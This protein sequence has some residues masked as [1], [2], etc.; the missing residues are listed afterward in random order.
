[1][2]PSPVFL[3]VHCC[4]QNG[5]WPL[6][7]CGSQYIYIYIPEGSMILGCCSQDILGSQP[8]AAPAPASPVQD[9]TH[10]ASV[11]SSQAEP[12][13]ELGG[14]ALQPGAALTSE[15]L[16]AARST[17]PGALLQGAVFPQLQCSCVPTQ[18][19]AQGDSLSPW[20]LLETY[21]GA[22]S[23]RF[24]KQTMQQSWHAGAS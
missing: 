11:L 15:A 9:A 20:D 14:A 10:A 2:Q 17:E 7:P 18:P 13:Q 8:R 5:D 19:E 3:A 1:M 24:N 12:S 6:H 16:A 22:S 4:L 21:H 23:C